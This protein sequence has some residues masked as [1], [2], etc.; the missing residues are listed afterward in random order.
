MPWCTY[1]G[2][3][4]AI[5]AALSAIAVVMM[6]MSARVCAMVANDGSLGGPHTFKFPL[7]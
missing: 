4:P 1:V 6:R 3:P 2:A 7:N 5:A